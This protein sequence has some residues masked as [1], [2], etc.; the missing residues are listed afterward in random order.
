MQANIS[1]N[2]IIKFYEKYNNE[3]E[4]FVQIKGFGDKCEEYIM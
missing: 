2:K 1:L 3:K 4:N